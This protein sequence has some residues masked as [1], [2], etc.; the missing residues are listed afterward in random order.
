ML[1]AGQM[2][3]DDKN[4]ALEIATLYFRCFDSEVGRLVLEDLACK[5]LARPIVRPNEDAYAQGIREGRADLVRQILNQVEFA[6]SPED[7]KNGVYE[8][9][10]KIIKDTY[11]EHS[12]KPSNRT[13]TSRSK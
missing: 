1:E 4:K 8:W 11:G 13:R 10:K 3:D 2:L 5:F 12:P 7:P 6:K 9:H